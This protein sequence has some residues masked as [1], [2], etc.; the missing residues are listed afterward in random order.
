MRNNPPSLLGHLLALEVSQIAVEEAVRLG[1]SFADARLEVHQREDLVVRNGQVKQAGIK[2]DRGLGLRVLV[3]GAW[4]FA[5]VSQPSRHDAVVL[6]RRAVDI[7][8]GAAIVQPH[9]VILAFEGPHSSVYRTPIERDPLGVPI[10][11]KLDLLLKIDER[12]RKNPKISLSIAGLVAHRVRKLY[13]NSDGSEIDQDLVYTGV[14]YQAGATDGNELQVRSF[15]DSAGGG[16]A[17]RGWEYVESLPLLDR[18]ESIAAEAVE[19][20]SADP[21]PAK[22]TDLILGGR[23]MALQIHESCGHPT[24][25]D[26]VLG[27]ERNFAGTSFLTPDQLGT[28]QYGSPL[29]NLYADARENGAVGSFGFDDEGVEAQSVD[30][31]S[32]GRFV[33]YL[34]SRDTAKRVGLARSSGAMR[35][36]SWAHVPI[37]RMTNVSLAPGK[38]G[39]LDDLIADTKDGV[40][41]DV[42]RS[43]SIDDRRMNFQFGCEEAWEVKDGKKTRRLKNPT[44]QGVTPSFW[45]SCDAIG[46]EASWHMYG[47]QF[48]GKGQPLQLITV[49]HGTAPARFKNV[50]LGASATQALPEVSERDRIPFIDHPAAREEG[51]IEGGKRR[52]RSRRRRED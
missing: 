2:K 48:C 24:E 45:G 26:R 4:G 30:L 15:P 22:V 36:S 31:V 7:A 38:G 49:G 34:S 10:E 14:G 42:N 17:A 40:Y 18:A 20:L 32:E 23:Q 5:A 37:V 21:C 44:Y 29:V 39:S 52:S 51:K 19:L 33:G 1:A 47:L 13:V 46:G 25:L 41:M 3:N 28:L 8:R 16:F 50:S 43:W 27:Q 6:A 35:A 11:D 12:L 9:P